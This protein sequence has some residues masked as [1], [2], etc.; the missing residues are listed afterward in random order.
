MRITKAF[1]RRF[2]TMIIPVF[3]AAL[4]TPASVHYL[5]ANA[6]T[7]TT[8]KKALYD[9]YWKEAETEL[10]RIQRI[11][12]AQGSFLEACVG[13][14]QSEVERSEIPAEY[15]T[16]T[17]LDCYADYSS[18]PINERA[19]IVKRNVLLFLAFIGFL[20]YLFVWAA[21]QLDNLVPGDIK[22]PLKIRDKLK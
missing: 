16:P 20:P 19:N 2:L 3:I 9:E 18:Y 7:V 5:F 1:H 21:N 22:D 15:Y 8:A 10:A 14:T 6:E 17:V 4:L 12:T 13:G 11:K